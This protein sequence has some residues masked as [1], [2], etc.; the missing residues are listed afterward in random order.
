MGLLSA[1]GDDQGIREPLLEPEAETTVSPS[2]GTNNFA[3]VRGNYF[4][5]ASNCPQDDSA[6]RVSQEQESVF[7]QGGFT[8]NDADELLVGFVNETGRVR[9]FGD[10]ENSD[11]NCTAQV[12]AGVM[13][14]SCTYTDGIEQTTCRYVY[15]T[16]IEGDYQ[17]VFNECEGDGT[18][19]EIRQTGSEVTLTDGFDYI[20][21]GGTETHNGVIENG[22]IAFNIDVISNSGAITDPI[23]TD[24]HNCEGVVSGNLFS[25]RC[26]DLTVEPATV[27]TFAFENTLRTAGVD[28]SDDSLFP[29]PA[30]TPNPTPAVV[31]NIAG[32]YALVSNDCEDDGGNIEISQVGST[33]GLVGGFDY[34]SPDPDI[35]AGSMIDNANFNFSALGPTE[36]AFCSAA[37]I[38]GPNGVNGFTGNCNVVDA[39]SNPVETC[40][41]SYSKI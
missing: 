36:R 40:A 38:F 1:C 23:T 17:P 20:K 7:M 32:T 14:G 37:V 6:L 4:L 25:G 2:V 28:L 9:F 11:P 12:D 34:Q 18:A 22:E 21:T 16:L 29:S 39:S 5:V 13:R 15:S 26:R 31:S 8:F 24:K 33:L 30:I 10:N 27:C 35:Y 3:V 41:F 19:L